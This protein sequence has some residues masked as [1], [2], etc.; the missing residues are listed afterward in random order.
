[1]KTKN[2]SVNLKK[3]MT[4]GVASALIV[5]MLTACGG[6]SGGD[7]STKTAGKS[8]QATDEAAK[9]FRFSIMSP[10]FAAQPPATDDSNAAFKELEAKT[11]VQMDVTFVPGTTYDDK[12]NVTLASGS[13]P[14]VM[15]VTNNKIAAVINAVRSGAFWEIGPYINEFPNLKKY[16]NDQV[17]NNISVDGKI[18]GIYRDRPVARKGLIFRQDWLDSLGLQP[19]KKVDDVYN[20]AKAFTLNDPD[21]NGKNDTYGLAISD[22]NLV[23]DATGVLVTALGGFNQWG[24]KDG[25]VTPD[26]MT[27]EYLDALKLLKK[28]YDEKLMNQ[29]FGA[30]KGTKLKETIN[31]GKAGM[32]I[33]SIDDANTSHSDLFKLNPKAK[34]GFVLGLEG[35]KGVKLPANSGYFGVFMFPKSSVK[36]E[37]D[38][39]KILA[40]FDKNLDPDI[41]KL[42]AFGVEGVHYKTENGNP[43][44]TNEQLW[45]D[46][47]ADLGQLRIAPSDLAWPT[48]SEVMKEVKKLYKEETPNAVANVIEPYL[49]P[50]YAERG[51]ELNKI[52]NDARVKFIMGATDEAGFVKAT[53][54][55]RKQ[56]GDKIIDEFTQ[57]YNKAQK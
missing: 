46:Q 3:W 37:A 30:I 11:G 20:I 45:A 49:S 25:K 7:G 16:W 6:G 28:M 5:S 42:F 33:S 26:F 50:T 18:Y 34:I 22:D 44:F 14:Q 21:K 35:P 4:A 8:G 31:Q 27:P 19:P 47:V 1:M 29:D 53:E 57:E 56:G 32:Y 13:L 48:E 15:V 23:N 54:D 51:T 24:I 41:L 2:K 55:W 12:L 39:K 10:F 36:T 52:I 9:P 38:L 17:A 40:Y 43:V